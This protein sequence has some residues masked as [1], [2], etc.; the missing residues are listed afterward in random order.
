MAAKKFV[1]LCSKKFV[2]PNALL[3]NKYQY[4]SG[5]DIFIDALDSDLVP[6]EPPQS[7][8][9][10][11]IGADKKPLKGWKLCNDQERVI[12]VNLLCNNIL[13]IL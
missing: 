13:L 12:S 2:D 7:A 9:L 6:E 5:A 4:L 10:S 8:L 11:M 3:P 1:E